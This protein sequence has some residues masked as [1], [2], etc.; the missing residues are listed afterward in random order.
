M[1][2]LVAIWREWVHEADAADRAA[3][4]VEP[5]EEGGIELLPERADRK[6]QA[7]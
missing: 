3:T 4:L 2:L 6:S 1:A 7:G 5:V